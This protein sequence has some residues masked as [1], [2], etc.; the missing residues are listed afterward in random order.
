MTVHQYKISE[1]LSLYKAKYDWE[2]KQEEIAYRV[3]QNKWL[4]GT[5][6]FNTTEIK[7]RSAE[8]DSVVDYGIRIAM[9]LSEI[10]TLHNRAW[11]GK[12]WSYIQDKN[13]KDPD[14]GFHVHTSAINFPDTRINA[15]ILTDWTYCFYLQVPADLQGNEGSLL[16]KDKDGKVYAI[17]PEE[18]DFIFFKG[19]VEHKP[20]LAPN[21]EGTRIA[22]C[23]NISF[24]ILE[25]KNDNIR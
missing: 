21:S 18:G 5:T 1:T 11:I 10:D 12:T 23:S 3:R 13:S 15:P 20:N 6:D 7:V 14:N 24:N 2:Y 19:D 22:I 9:R 8:I 25:I 17:K 16:L 4:L